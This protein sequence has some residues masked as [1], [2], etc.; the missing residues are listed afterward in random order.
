MIIAFIQNEELRGTVER[1][2][3]GYDRDLR[4]AEL[5][6]GFLKFYGFRMDYVTQKIVAKKP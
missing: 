4:T 1:N 3:E 2:G 6:V 5:L